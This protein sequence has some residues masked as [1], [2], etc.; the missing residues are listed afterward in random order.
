[1]FHCST[2]RSVARS[3]LQ[4]SVLHYSGLHSTQSHATVHYIVWHWWHCSHLPLFVAQA[5]N[6]TSK[7]CA[8][9]H[10]HHHRHHHHCHQHHHHH[11]HCHHQREFVAWS[12]SH[13]WF[14]VKYLWWYIWRERYY[15]RNIFNLRHWR[16]LMWYGQGLTIWGWVFVMRYLMWHIGNISWGIL[17][18]SFGKSFSTRLHNVC[19]S[20]L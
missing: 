8:S 13:D 10:H 4:W 6:G 16:Y 15:T 19:T 18:S 9:C 11:H 20:L 1:M 7:T 17:W 3:V 14:S 2:I 12:V 5:I